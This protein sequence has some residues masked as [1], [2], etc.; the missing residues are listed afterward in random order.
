[1]GTCTCIRIYNIYVFCFVYQQAMQKA[2]EVRDQLVDTMKQQGI[3]E[4]SCGT[5]W[6][7]LR[8]VF[9][10]C[11]FQSSALSSCAS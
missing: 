6:D 11:L 7:V 2:R 5:D 8:K 3:P 4:V 9:I 10:R 1:M